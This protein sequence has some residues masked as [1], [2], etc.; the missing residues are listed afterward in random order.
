[1]LMLL[2]VTLPVLI[3]A[4]GAAAT[5]CVQ[6]P[7]LYQRNSVPDTSSHHK[8]ELVGSAGAVALCIM[9]PLPLPAEGA[10]ATH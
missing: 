10:A 7:S 5:H 6:L 9:L 2:N 8:V 3:P 4:E 1:M